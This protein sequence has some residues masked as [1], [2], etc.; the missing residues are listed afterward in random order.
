M[1]HT[2]LL[3][4]S[5]LFTLGSGQGL[6]IKLDENIATL[7]VDQSGVVRSAEELF[8]LSSPEE[9]TKVNPQN[10]TLISS[11]WD[12]VSGHDAMFQ[13]KEVFASSSSFVRGTID[14]WAQHR[15]LVLRPDEVWFEVLA[16]LNF[17]MAANAEK[18]RGLFVSYSGTQRIRTASGSGGNNVDSLVT[19]I[20]QELQKRVRANWLVDWVKPGFSTSTNQDDVTASV[21]MMG[22]MSSYFDYYGHV[23][24]GIPSVT[25]LGTKAD[26]A[27]L[28]SKLDNLE[29][30]GEEP[31]RYASFLRPI[32]TGFVHSWENPASRETKDFWSKI[33][34]GRASKGCGGVPV[35]TGWITGFYFWD[36]RGQAIAGA[37]SGAEV[38]G[39]Q[40]WTHAIDDL[41]ISYAKVPVH[42]VGYP[43]V[44]EETEAYLLAGNIGTQRTMMSDGK[45]AERPLSGWFLYSTVSPIQKP[46][47]HLFGEIGV[48]GNHVKQCKAS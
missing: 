4:L 28:L 42:L 46:E 8:Y 48:I 14:A 35:A 23:V 6:K 17:Y 32:F 38:G 3:V 9:T 11:S 43:G 15:H 30:F 10:L 2:A 22:L 19:K 20:N 47:Y 39:V 12:G 37:R 5:G 1:H 45:A 16:Q 33:V 34:V 44:P 41:P 25:L 13:R 27:A 24:C 26:W 36:H 7:Q 29:K 21:L 40:Y 31:S 18:V